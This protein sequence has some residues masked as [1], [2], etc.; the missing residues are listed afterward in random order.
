MNPFTHST[1]GRTGAIIACLAMA[2]LALS[3]CGGSSNS[4]SSGSSN[5]GKTSSSKS[6]SASSTTS[7]SSTSSVVASSSLPFPIAVGNTWVFDATTL[8]GTSSTVTNKVLS[9]TPVSGGN[10]VTMSDTESLDNTTTDISY[11]FHSNGYITYPSTEFGSS[12]TVIKGGILLPSAA[13]IDSGQATTSTLE[14]QVHSGSINE[15][16]NAHI[17]VKGDGTA[18]VTEP[19]GTYSATIVQMA[20]AFTMMGTTET[21]VV[22]TW[23]ANGVGPVQS[24]ATIDTLGHTETVSELKLVSFTQG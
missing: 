3:A 6:P 10:E 11:I 7:T 17:T 22:K 12:A 5:A 19:A 20:E 8:A 16:V 23:M 9:V 2:G 21:I 18:T 24:E 14:L 15:T 13:V 1:R 4:G